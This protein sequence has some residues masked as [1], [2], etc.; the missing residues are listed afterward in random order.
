[1]NSPGFYQ[2]NPFDNELT[3]FGELTE[4]TELEVDYKKK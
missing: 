4:L 3:E 2:S 1:M